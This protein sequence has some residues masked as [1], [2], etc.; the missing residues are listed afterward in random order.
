[1]LLVAAGQTR[2]TIAE[3]MGVSAHTAQTHGRNI[4]AKLGV[5]TRAAL[6]ETLR[7]L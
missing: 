6:F 7:A 1:V 3:R 2:A 4:Y 5:H